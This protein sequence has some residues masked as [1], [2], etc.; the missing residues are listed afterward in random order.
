MT[1]FAI[2]LLTAIVALCPAQ[3]GSSFEGAWVF[4][5]EGQ[6]I[7]VLTLAGRRGLVTGSLTKPKSLV[8]NQDGD[9]SGIGP[10]QVTLPVQKSTLAPERLDLIIDGDRLVMTLV[11]REHAWLELEGMRPWKLDRVPIGSP[12]ILATSLAEPSYPDEIHA[13]RRQLRAMEKEDQDARLAFQKTRI[14][15]SDAKNQP[16]LENIFAKYGWVTNSLAGKDASHDFWLLIQHQSHA[17]QKRLLPALEAAAKAG[18]AS[19]SDYAYLYDRVQ[20]GLGQPQHWGTQIACVDGQPTLSPV[21]DPAG[22]D[23]RRKE[24]F[25]LPVRDYLKSDYFDKLCRKGAK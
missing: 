22:L 17:M 5:P 25:M 10:D 20:V 6:N 15:A 24:L 8:I 7:F 1:R 2:I 19:M 21:D 14:D 4:R 12:V 16:E 23:A 13:L 11:D 3:Q 18:D 9:V